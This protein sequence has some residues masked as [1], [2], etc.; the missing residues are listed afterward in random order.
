MLRAVVGRI[1]ATL[2]FADPRRIEPTV[3]SSF[4]SHHTDRDTVARYMDTARRMLPEMRDPFDLPRMEGPVLLVWGDRDRLVFSSGAQRV[5]D[6]VPGARLERFA[7]CGHCPQ[8]EAPE[9][10]ANLLLEFSAQA[11][12]AA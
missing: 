10:F 3:I 6:E 8:I 11:T 5:L 4:T 1:Y 2:A 7:R 9:R 12:A